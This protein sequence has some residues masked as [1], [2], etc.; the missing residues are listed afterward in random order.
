MKIV[1]RLMI[2][3]LASLLVLSMV[4]CSNAKSVKS[5]QEHYEDNRYVYDEL[6]NNTKV[7]G[8]INFTVKENSIL[9]TVTFNTAIKE[10]Q[11][12]TFRSML[13]KTIEGSDEEYKKIVEGIK[14]DVP[15]GTFIVEYRDKNNVFL[16]NKEYK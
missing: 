9:M 16:V 11:I 6:A 2:F 15:D 8:V 1:K 3:S 12:E 7:D 14:K 13:L 5:L 10:S 4:G